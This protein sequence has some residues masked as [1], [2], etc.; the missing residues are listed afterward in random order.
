MLRGLGEKEELDK[1]AKEDIKISVITESKRTLHG[2]KIVQLFTVQLTD[3]SP[4]VSRQ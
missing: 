4:Q 1:T 2:N 3:N